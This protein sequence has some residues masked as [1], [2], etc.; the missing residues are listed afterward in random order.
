MNKNE[1]SRITR[2]LF[3]N[4]KKH[5]LEFM[6]NKRRGSKKAHSR[7]KERGA[8]DTEKLRKA[9][10]IDLSGPALKAIAV[11]MIENER[12]ENAQ[13]ERG[14]V[15]NQ[16]SLSAMKEVLSI[17]PFKPVVLSP[18]VTSRLLEWDENNNALEKA[19]PHT[20][21][22]AKDGISPI[23]GSSSYGEQYIVA[24]I[25]EGLEAVVGNLYVVHTDPM[26]GKE[27]NAG[28]YI[29]GNEE[30]T[31]FIEMSN[32]KQSDTILFDKEIIEKLSEE[33]RNK[34]TILTT[35]YITFYLSAATTSPAQ[36]EAVTAC[37]TNLAAEVDKSSVTINMITHNSNMGYRVRSIPMNHWP[38]LDN[39]DIKLHYG[40]NFLE[41]STALVKKVKETSKGI[42]MLHGPP[43][44]GKT[45]YIR[46]LTSA[47]TRAGKQVFMIPKG[48]V[49]MIQ[50]PGFVD[51]MIN[52]FSSSG[53]GG[54]EDE[55]KSGLVFI[56]EDAESLLVKRN[57]D[58]H[59]AVGVS[60]LLNLTDGI[61]NDLFNVQIIATFNTAIDNLDEALL[62]KGRLLAIRE[63]GLL[64][65]NEAK[66]LSQHL[67]GN[68]N[69]VTKEMTLSEVYSLGVS[70]E[71]TILTQNKP[72]KKMRQAGFM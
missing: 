47:L 3:H 29:F 56:I 7:N 15:S 9:M 38:E 35:G 13:Q 68:S 6:E 12:E 48:V 71:E 40:D 65:F 63:L 55:K 22:A 61:L 8:I 26:I 43:G 4:K 44:T 16:T 30:S 69:N 39:N 51:F 25:I 19:R 45:Y 1:F 32:V 23:R 37:I 14:N 42:V 59:A 50:D 70:E 57:T 2:K 36:I 17:R 52:H 54:I 58:S 11:K 64:D 27:Q 60:T 21:M 33:Q 20:W 24:E 62:R 18:D 10:N 53:A 46:R 31:F 66:R 34:E 41:F 67:H 5:F 49:D 28:S 72:A